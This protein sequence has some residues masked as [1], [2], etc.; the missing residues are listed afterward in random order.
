MK[1]GIQLK[2]THWIPAYAGMTPPIWVPAY[3]DNYLPKISEKNLSISAFDF[4]S[5][6]AL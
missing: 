5:A 1:T 4:W 2:R 3:G 6:S